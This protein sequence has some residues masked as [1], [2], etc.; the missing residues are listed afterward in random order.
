MLW[1]SCC[2]HLVAHGDRSTSSSYTRNFRP[3]HLTM[4]N[5]NQTLSEPQNRM[6]DSKGHLMKTFKV[7]ALGSTANS[8]HSKPSP[9]SSLSTE[10]KG[11]IL[12]KLNINF[13]SKK[14]ICRGA[15]C[16]CGPEGSGSDE[17]RALRHAGRYRRI[18]RWRLKWNSSREDYELCQRAES[19]SS[20]EWAYS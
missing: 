9:F 13:R 5:R 11:W 18:R 19:S 14:P 4:A 1:C 16:S 3:C 20:Y 15:F 12:Q 17:N 10:G 2:R 6:S 8:R 7:K